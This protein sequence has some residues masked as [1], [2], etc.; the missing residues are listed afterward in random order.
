MLRERGTGYT[1]GPDFL[2][3]LLARGPDNPGIP[4]G[5]A[6]GW[7]SFIYAAMRTSA[8]L[9]FGPVLAPIATALL[10][11]SVDFSLDPV[12][13]GLGYWT[14]KVDDCQRGPCTAFSIPLDNFLG[15][16][17][18]VGAIS[19]TLRLGYK[20]AA[21]LGNKLA[22]E[23]AFT[24]VAMVVALALA[25]AIQL[26]YGWLYERVTT[27]G[28][29]LLVYGAAA[30]LTLSRLPWLRRDCPVDPWV[31]GLVGY[32]HLYLLLMFFVHHDNFLAQPSLLAFLP[33]VAVSSCLAFAWPSLSALGA[34]L[35]TTVWRPGIKANATADAQ[36]RST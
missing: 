33:L 12:A 18:I 36:T 8:R 21:A 5:V 28:T 35:S 32:F 1:Y 22:L 4:L 19:F 9:G 30:L 10:A 25:V 29:F 26:V 23:I 11:A 20:A 13:E 15:W 17:M 3:Y 31:L 34:W 7:G 6:L 14:W 27:A 16:M 24:A 2:V